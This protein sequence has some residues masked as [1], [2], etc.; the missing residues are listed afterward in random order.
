MMNQKIIRFKISKPEHYLR[1][2]NGIY[3]LTLSERNVL[4]EFI[5]VYLAL[6]EA[7]SDMNPF[8][9]IMK[10]RVAR[11]L[12]KDNFNSLNTYIQALGTKKA[13]TRVKGGY[14]INPH[15]IPGGEDEIV[16]RIK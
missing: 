7:G 8:S 14:K 5:R 15:L 9:T 2:F 1:L 12:G 13:I 3:N 10:K 4:S 6:K 16:F 11:R